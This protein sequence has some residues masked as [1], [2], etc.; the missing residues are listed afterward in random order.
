[1]MASLADWR[2]YIQRRSLFTMAG[3]LIGLGVGIALMLLTPPTYTATTT[4]VVERNGKNKMDGYAS[5]AARFGLGSTSSGNGLFLDDDNLMSFLRSRTVIAQTLRSVPK[6]RPGSGLLAD[7]FLTMS[8]LRDKWKGV[9]SL[10]NLRFHSD[11]AESTVT[12]DSVISLC[13]T[14]I[15]RENLII[16]KPDPDLS[17]ISVSTKATDQQFAKAFDEEILQR[18]AAFY[19]DYQTKKSMENV[20]ILRRQVDSVRG[21]LNGALA[22]VASS[23]DA[24]PNLNPAFQRARVPSQR[25]LIDVEINKAI[26]TELVKNLEIAEISLRQETPLI[27]VIDTPVLPLEKKKIGMLRG[28]AVG[29][30]IGALLVVVWFTIRYVYRRLMGG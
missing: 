17:I 28:P 16:G 9:P 23:N 7:Q 24:N 15:V 13:Y 22:G 25:R 20:A 11:P 14:M 1:M 19:I 21:V 18:V 6:S 5:I 3:L 10:S 30:F 29:A 27:Q 26:L 8:G 12:E 2:S 4:F